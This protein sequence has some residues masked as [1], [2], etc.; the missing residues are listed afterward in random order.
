MNDVIVSIGT[1]SNSTV[2]YPGTYQGRVVAVKDIS[3]RHLDLVEQEVNTLKEVDWHPNIVRYFFVDLHR[4]DRFCYIAIEL[5]LR[6]L[7]NVMHG[8]ETK[9]CEI[10]EVFDRKKAMKEITSGFKHMHGLNIAH[11]DIK[12]QN[13]LYISPACELS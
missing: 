9:Y 3:R 12:P 1:G 11:R 7:A 8:K 6:S 10:R 5:C 2:V 13:I 4:N